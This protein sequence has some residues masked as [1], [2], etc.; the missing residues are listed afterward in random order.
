MI[1]RTV[2]GSTEPLDAG[3]QH[4]RDHTGVFRELL[5]NI[6]VFKIERAEDVWPVYKYALR[7]NGSTLIIEK[8]E[9]YNA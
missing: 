9:L 7:Y 3:I 8:G 1:I 6:S 4:R 5:H 2:I